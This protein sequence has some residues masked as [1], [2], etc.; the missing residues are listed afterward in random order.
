M[1]FLIQGE[2]P[3][4]LCP[5]SNEA[6]RKLASEGGQE[7]PALG[8]K[9]GRQGQRHLRADDEPQGLRRGGGGQH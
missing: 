8:E 2:H 7:M 1:H 4:D 3:P 6:I 9:A 5:A